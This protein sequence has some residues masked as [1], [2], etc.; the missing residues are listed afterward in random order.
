MY[1]EHKDGKVKVPVEKFKTEGI[2]Y[3]RNSFTDYS[4][5]EI[6]NFTIPVQVPETKI[7]GSGN[8]FTGFCMQVVTFFIK[9]GFLDNSFCNITIKASNGM[10]NACNVIVTND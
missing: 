7:P 4:T 9:I 10:A 6:G 2:G 5:V 3:I 8:P 1:T